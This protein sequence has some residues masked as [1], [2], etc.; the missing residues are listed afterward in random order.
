MLVLSILSYYQKFEGSNPYFKALG[1]AG[2]PEEVIRGHIAVCTSELASLKSSGVVPDTPNTVFERVTSIFTFWIPTPEPTTTPM[3]PS[4]GGLLLSVYDWV[5]VNESYRKALCSPHG[6]ATSFGSDPN[7]ATE[8]L[9]D[10]L[11]FASGIFT[12]VHGLYQACYTK[13]CMTIFLCLTE[14]P[15]S[16]EL[17]HSP[18]IGCY[19]PSLVEKVFI[20]SISLYHI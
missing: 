10:L 13:M 9:Q 5:H 3:I 4:M 1:S 7:Q 16:A 19:I 14:D 2:I 6:G 20:I 17:L 15:G 11:Q 12:D 8:L 18:E